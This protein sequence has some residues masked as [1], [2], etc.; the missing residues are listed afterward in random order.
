MKKKNILYALTGLVTL[1]SVCLTSCENAE[2]KQLTDQAFITQTNTNGNTI[3]RLAVDVDGVSSDISVRLSNPTA[4]TCV[5]NFVDNS[6]V[7]KAYNEE[8]GTNYQPLPEKY[9]ALSEKDFTIEAGKALSNT[10]FLKVKAIPE[11]MTKNGEKYAVALRLTSKDG[12]KEVL[13]SGSTILYLLDKV[14]KQPVPTITNESVVTVKLAKDQDVTLKDWTLEYNVR[15]SKLG[16]AKGELANQCIFGAWAPSGM[17]GEIYTRFGDAQVEGNK[18]QIKTQGVQVNTN[19]TFE[20]NKWYHIAFV[21]EGSKLTLYVN[22]K[23]DVTL[24]VPGKPVTLAHNKIQLGNSDGL[25]SD[26]N[27]SELRLWTV[28]RTGNQII[29]NMYNVDPN[30][31]NLFMYFKLNEGSGYKFTDITKNKHTAFSNTNIKWSKPIR[32]DGK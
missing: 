27:I 24:D 11:E 23:A 32:I 29:N 19:A 2:Y 13:N 1:S 9:Y 22:G 6:G 15:I 12:A 4:N 30:A 16:K 18:I 17:D 20:P 14:V 7:L 25:K 3:K 28:A 26:L 31:E 21:C 10:A 8:N 5:F